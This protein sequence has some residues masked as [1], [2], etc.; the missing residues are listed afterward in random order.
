MSKVTIA[1]GRMSSVFIF[2]V[3]AAEK[4][5]ELIYALEKKV[6]FRPWAISTKGTSDLKIFN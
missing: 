2:G 6:L 1:E 3:L 4:L 5:F